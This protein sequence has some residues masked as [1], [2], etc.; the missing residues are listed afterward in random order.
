MVALAGLL[1]QRQHTQAET[2]ARK[3]IDA[4]PSHGGI[5]Q[6]L[7]AALHA[8]GKLAEAVDA[9]RK[10]AALSPWDCIAHYAL[11]ESLMAMKQPVLAAESYHLASRIKPDFADA[12]FKLGNALAAQNRLE[13]A[14]AAYRS[15]LQFRPDFGEAH[16]NLGFSLLSAHRHAEAEPHLRQAL[17][18]HPDSAPLHNALGTVLYGQSHMTAAAESFRRVIMLTPDDAQAHVNLGNALRELG[19]FSDAEHSYRHA[20]ALNSRLARAHYDLGGLFYVQEYYAK[21]EHSYRRALELQP[22]YVEACNNLGRSIRRQ[23]RLEQAREYFEA[24]VTID[25][26][27]VEAYCN[28]ASLRTFRREHLEP[29]RLEKLAHKL[30]SLSENLRIRYWFSLGK[31]REDLGRYDQAFA[32]YAQG[33][34]LKHAQLS[35]DEAGK[36]ALIEQVRSVFDRR[37]FASR[38]IPAVSGKGKTPIFIVGMPRSGTSLIEQILSTHPDIYGAGEL[39]DL[40]NIL[41]ALADETG[42]PWTD[43]PEAAAR[44]STEEL[45][46]LGKAY[47]DRVWRHAPHASRITDKMMANF[48]YIGMIRLMLPNAKII[49]AMR[50]PMDSC[51]SCYATLFSRNNLDFTYDLGEV[52][53]YYVRYIELMRHWQQVLPP[54]SILELRYEDMVADTEGQAR[55]LLDYLGLPWNRRCL[56]FHQN[57]RVVRTASAAQVRRPVYRSSVARWKNFAAHLQ[58]LLEIVS[59]YQ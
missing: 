38:P 42:K 36:I 21:A 3:L 56:N 48:A 24:A 29:A 27:S 25:P 9:Q 41:F 52:G 19:S 49:H 45:L 43:F 26:E 23:G 5:W 30:P 44:L 53:R 17:V 28:L 20:I 11:G 57:E 35:P 54:G 37:F 39:P 33:N 34:R 50:D 14:I 7:G 31:M 16:A 12:H 47:T 15:V 4:Y 22:D 46:R 8:Q 59:A 13:E 55:R 18:A 58:P 51:L 32:A 6:A 2:A 40:E 1:R 10:A